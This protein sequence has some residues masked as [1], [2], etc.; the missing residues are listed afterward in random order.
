MR[1]QAKNVAA[2]LALRNCHTISRSIPRMESMTP[3]INYGAV[4]PGCIFR[5]GFPQEENHTFLQELKLK[6]VL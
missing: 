6:T 3:P 4:I 2:G 1:F 5:S